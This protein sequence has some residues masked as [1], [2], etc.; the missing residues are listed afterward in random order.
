ME[1]A[2]WSSCWWHRQWMIAEGTGS[3]NLEISYS[4]LKYKVIFENG[5][6]VGLNPLD[7]SN[8]NENGC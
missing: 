8:L 4:A 2:E 1:Q 3:Y 7:K 5:E 6:V